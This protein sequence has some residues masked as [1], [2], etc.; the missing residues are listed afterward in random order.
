[1]LLERVGAIMIQRP[2]YMERLINAKDKEIIKVITGVRRS[3]KST[4][5]K[6]FR[7][8]LLNT[9]IESDQIQYLNM[10]I[11]SDLELYHFK[12]LYDFLDS[13][14]VTGKNN[15]IFLDEIQLVDNFEKTINSLF[16]KGNADIYITGSN[17]HMLSG[18][19]ATLLSGRYIELH[20]LPL[21]FKEYY[22]FVL[23]EKTEAFQKYLDGGGF[24]YS[25]QIDDVRT[26]NDYITGIINTVLLKDV[27]ARNKRGD[28]LLV[29]QLAKFLASSAGNFITMKKIVDTLVSYGQ[30]TTS[31]T[32]SS[33]LV[34]L[35][36][37][38]LFY[39]CDRYDISG[40]KYLS[41]NSK[42]YSVDTSLKTALV[43]NRR[44]NLGSRLESI[45]YIE[46]KRRGYEIYVGTTNNYEVDFIAIKDGVTEYYQVSLTVMDDNT[47][48]REVRSLLEIKDNYRKILL[49]QDLGYYNDNG[50]EQI[51]VIE[52]LLEE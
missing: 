15:Y 34:S 33:Y 8:Y 44:L 22:S 1:M 27:L 49:T 47:Y 26:Y 28:A 2:E 5:M 38:F 10:E 36:E 46:L 4:I 20:V 45:V 6:M 12:K 14:L 39:R 32:V 42:Y 17:A 23:G 13:R 51:N 35:I 7:D 48:D 9:R 50:I 52:W 25:L 19:L 43:G 31:E 11:I 21:S 41:T 30:K 3:G 24:P 40:K 16:A 37:S 29:E 18:E